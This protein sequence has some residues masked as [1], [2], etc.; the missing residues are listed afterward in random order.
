LHA[1]ALRSLA[2]WLLESK[3]DADISK[4]NRNHYQSIRADLLEWQKLNAAAFLASSVA[5]KFPE[6][7]G[8]PFITASWTE[9]LPFLKLPMLNLQGGQRPANPSCVYANKRASEDY[10]L[11]SIESLFL[12]Q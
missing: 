6:T 8:R 5:V 10:T 12:R 11:A 4:Q 9:Y 2:D 7:Y 3:S 1:G